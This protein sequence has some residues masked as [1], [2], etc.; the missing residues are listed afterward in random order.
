MNSLLVAFDALLRVLRP[1]LFALAVVVALVCLVD[2]LVRTRRL[3]PFG[4]V[5]RFFRASISPLMAPV[6]RRVVRS[7]GLPSSAP[8]WT[9]AAVVLGGIVVLSLL[10]FLRGQL[11]SVA[12]AMSGG[13]S[14]IVWL[15]VSWTF[16]ILRLA[17]MVR[18]FS[19]FVRISPYSP[20][21]RWSY[22]LSE[23]MLRPL[24]QII[25]TLGMFDLTPI[26]AY[27]LL[28]VLESLIHSIA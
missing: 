14:S 12:G 25:P 23:P 15:L 17:L 22:V 13:P 19:S 20:W 2:W 24:R 18:V 10:G 3:N 27:L 6:E 11:V 26:V 7:G 4:P 9:L 16:A 5:A 1:T 21:I 8:W 28:G